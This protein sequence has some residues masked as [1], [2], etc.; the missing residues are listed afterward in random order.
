[1]V[2]KDLYHVLDDEQVEL[3]NEKGMNNQQIEECFQKKGLLNYR[4]IAKYKIAELESL[5]V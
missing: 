5:K 3:L 4:E 1:M 2:A